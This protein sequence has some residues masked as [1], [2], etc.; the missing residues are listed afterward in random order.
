MPSI[1]LLA[2]TLRFYNGLKLGTNARDKD[3][4][5]VSNLAQQPSIQVDY[6][7]NH[8]EHIPTIAQWHHTQW[9][10]LAPHVSLADRM[11][12]LSMN[13]QQG[14]I[15]TTFVVLSQDQPVGCAS[16]VSS[17]LSIRD[18]LSPWLA[19][20][21]VLP[22]FRD[23]GIG[24][25]LVERAIQEA[26]SLDIPALYLYTPD[27]QSFYTRLGWRTLEDCIYRGFEMTVMQYVVSCS[28]A[29]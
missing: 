8:R 10:Y 21:F 17:D 16:L 3:N 9:R 6:L 19:S 20:V 23:A 25:K 7:A 13:A 2:R 15:P 28:P 24:S 4:M 18:T 14:G 22:S 29:G 27:R 26:K 11:E 5:S 12:R 1:I